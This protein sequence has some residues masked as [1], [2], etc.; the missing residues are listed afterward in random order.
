MA[1]ATAPL[2]VAAALLVIAGLPKVLRPRDTVGALR[3]VGVRAPARLVRLGGAAEAAAG[4]AAPV[5]GGAIPAALVALSYLGFTAFLAVA[6]GRGGAIASCGC[7]GRSD[8]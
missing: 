3:S 5:A 1:P 8:T 7:L 6:L 4:V 2:L